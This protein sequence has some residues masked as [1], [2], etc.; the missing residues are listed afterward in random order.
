MRDR[1]MKIATS[2]PVLAGPGLAH[3][4]PGHMPTEP[5]DVL[6]CDLGI[7]RIANRLPFD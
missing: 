5:L 4:S 1:A 2:T 3:V 7:R 6:R